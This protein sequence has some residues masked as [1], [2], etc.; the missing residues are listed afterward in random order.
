MGKDLFSRE[1]VSRIPQD[2]PSDQAAAVSQTH[3]GD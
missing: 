3:P 1:G 2:T